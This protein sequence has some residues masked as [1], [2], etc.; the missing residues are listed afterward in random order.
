MTPVRH[1]VTVVLTLTCHLFISGHWGGSAHTLFKH[2]GPLFCFFFLWPWFWLK[3][4]LSGR[5]RN[6]LQNNWITI[7]STFWTKCRNFHIDVMTWSFSITLSIS[8]HQLLATIP[9]PISPFYTFCFPS[10]LSLSLSL[11]RYW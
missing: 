8:S 6:L 3:R 5:V 2:L 4:E 11:H 9:K 1:S 7:S 10:L